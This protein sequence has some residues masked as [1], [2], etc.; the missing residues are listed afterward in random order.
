MAVLIV[1][2][3]VKLLTSAGKNEISF[4]KQANLPGNFYALSSQ[5]LVFYWY[6]VVSFWQKAFLYTSLVTYLEMW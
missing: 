4:R 6:I 2:F 5:L 1:E 3:T